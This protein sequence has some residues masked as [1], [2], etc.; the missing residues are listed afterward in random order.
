MDSFNGIKC[1]SIKN[2]LLNCRTKNKA[3]T[4]FYITWFMLSL[5]KESHKNGWEKITLVFI[6]IRNIKSY[7]RTEECVYH[8]YSVPPCR[9][10]LTYHHLR[11][12]PLWN[13]GSKTGLM[14]F[15]PLPANYSYTWAESS[16]CNGPAKEKI[17]AGSRTDPHSQGF[18]CLHFH[19]VSDHETMKP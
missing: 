1:M 5:L 6:Y 9:P 19:R 8:Q 18:I 17:A 7:A 3:S 14:L 15:Q 10:L 16:E 2:I 12:L 11:F 4:Q 13:Y